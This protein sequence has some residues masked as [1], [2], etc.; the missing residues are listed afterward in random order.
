MSMVSSG[1]Q[2]PLAGREAGIHNLDMPR[3][4]DPEAFVPV[5]YQGLASGRS[6]PSTAAPA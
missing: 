6:S 3:A 4:G 1:D 2:A 5:M